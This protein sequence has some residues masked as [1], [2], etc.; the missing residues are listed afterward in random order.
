[1][2]AASL[3]PYLPL[4]SVLRASIIALLP[5]CSWASDLVPPSVA[6]VGEHPESVVSD[7]SYIYVSNIG[8]FDASNDGYISRLS[9]Q[10]ELLEQKFL[11]KPGVLLDV[12]LGLTIANKRLFVADV[13]MVRGFDLHTGTQVF[14]L[15]LAPSGATFLNDVA[16]IDESTLLISEVKQRKLYVVDIAKV[17]ARAIDVPAILGQPNGL[18]FDRA[19][20]MLYYAGNAVHAAKQPEG[21]GILAAMRFHAKAKKLKPSWIKRMGKFLDG[22]TAV[23]GL[24]VVSDWD[25][26]ELGGALHLAKRAGGRPLKHVQF[27]I[28]GYADH[29]WHAPTMTLM[30]PHLLEGKLSLQPLPDGFSELLR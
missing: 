14:A 21:N 18:W 23:A 1:M 25:E 29:F 5:C 19:T 12:A 13:G 3:L 28:R 20:G 11:P 15:D 16:V 17:S 9:M 30:Q 2:K 27:P 6:L 24:L 26:P 4:K 22:I 8:A 10:G 7:G